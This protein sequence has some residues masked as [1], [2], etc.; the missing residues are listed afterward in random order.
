MEAEPYASRDDVMKSHFAVG[1][2]DSL[3]ENG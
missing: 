1:L 2:L 3:R